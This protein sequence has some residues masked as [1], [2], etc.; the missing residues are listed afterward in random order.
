MISRSA[1]LLPPP[2]LSPSPPP[3]PCR[4]ADWP[5]GWWCVARVVSGG[6]S[7]LPLGSKL[8]LHRVRPHLPLALCTLLCPGPGVQHAL[9]ADGPEVT[10]LWGHASFCGTLCLR[11]FIGSC[12]WYVFWPA[13]APSIHRPVFLFVSYCTLQVGTCFFVL[14]CTTLCTPA[15][16][17][18]LSPFCSFQ[19]IHTCAGWLSTCKC[20][21]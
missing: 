11:A 19:H 18:S 9:M 3:P 13:C 1:P 2:P 16:V 6:G 4:C 14:H 17:I 10:L 21:A 12:V 15:A 8:R 7:D 5:R 20:V